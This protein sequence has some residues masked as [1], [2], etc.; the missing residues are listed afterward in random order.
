MDRQPETKVISAVILMLL[1][2]FACSA[3]QLRTFE[4]REK[5]L[6]PKVFKNVNGETLL[7]R[8][9]IPQ[10][11]E[12]K[13]KYPL[14]LYLHGGGGSGNDNRKQ[15]DGGNGYLIDL[16]TSN[17]TQ[18]RYPSFVVAPQAPAQ[19]GWIGERVSPTR[20]LRL[21]YELIGELRRNYNIDDAR[22]YVAGQSMG[23][24]G[25]FA[26]ISEYPRVFAAG[27]ALCGGGDQ[28]KVARLLNTPIW[29]FHGAKDEAVPVERSRTIVA[30]IRDAGGHVRYTE[31]ADTGHIIWPK[32]VKE[33]DLLPWLFAQRK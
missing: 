1:F 26:I 21:V 7:Y 30:A 6:L 33:N 10:N 3:Q 11:Y 5:I 12:S 22:V 19:E 31:Y 8:L 17:E 14:V 9:Y 23:G 20:Q 24:F 25:T 29:A 15:V 27:V 16:F 13:R 32:V 2:S 4:Q 28:S 18:A